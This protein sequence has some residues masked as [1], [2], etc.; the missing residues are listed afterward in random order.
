MGVDSN[1]SQKTL[2]TQQQRK[3]VGKNEI[4]MSL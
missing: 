3:I 2:A 4:K 1:P